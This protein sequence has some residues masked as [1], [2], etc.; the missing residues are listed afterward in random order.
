VEELGRKMGFT[1]ARRNFHSVSLGQG[2]EAVAERAMAEA[3]EKGHWV[4]LQNIHLVR[5]WLPKLEK[6]L[7]QLAETADS[8]YRLFMSAEPAPN[9][10][11]HILPQV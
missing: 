2:Q 9:P 10:A 3:A 11:N 4:V 5:G 7:E 8:S 1:G 6:K